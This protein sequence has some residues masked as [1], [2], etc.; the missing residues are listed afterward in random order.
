M[1]LEKYKRLS[2]KWNIAVTK[3]IAAYHEQLNSGLI[4]NTEFLTKMTKIASRNLMMNSYIKV[5]SIENG[6]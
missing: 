1:N 2:I 3:F 4:T 5:W 6:K